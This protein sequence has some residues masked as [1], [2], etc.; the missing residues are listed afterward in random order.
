MAAPRKDNERQRVYQH[1]LE[2][3][4]QQGYTKTKYSDIAKA[5]G[6]TKSMVQ[7][8]FPKKELLAIE[9][10]NEHLE[11]L[12]RQVEKDAGEDP[13]KLFCMMG[14]RH[15]N[16]LLNNEEYRYFIDDLLSNRE[17]TGAIVE[18]E[19]EWAQTRI[20]PPIEGPVYVQDALTVALG[21]AYELIFHAQ[22]EGKPLSASYVEYAGIVPFAL[23]IGYDRDTI[24]GILEECISEFDPTQP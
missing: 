3:F 22:K 21:G 9:F 23:S 5:C 18:A 2:L 7:H 16:F 10:L 12:A 24:I 4:R 1:A 11:E 8:Y 13:L 20:V 19:R 17:L 6:G 15:F 14:L